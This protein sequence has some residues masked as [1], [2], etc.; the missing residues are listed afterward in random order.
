VVNTFALRRGSGISSFLPSRH[1][2]LI[3]RVGEK[4]LPSVTGGRGEG[5]GGTNKEQSTEM[6]PE[7]GCEVGHAKKTGK[8]GKMTFLPEEK[9][10]KQ[11]TEVE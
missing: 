11:T 9:A 10:R 5:F 4:I 6:G 1:S 7:T 3:A 2:H 8:G